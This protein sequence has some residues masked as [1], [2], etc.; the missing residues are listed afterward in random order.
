M[1][2]ENIISA[3]EKVLAWL[4]SVIF[5]IVINVQLMNQP[6]AA[7]KIIISGGL[8]KADAVC[9]KI[10]DLTKAQ[11][12]RSENADATVQGAAYM[13]AGLPQQ[14]ALNTEVEVFVPRQNPA[15]DNR[16]TRWQAAM[17][18]WLSLEVLPEK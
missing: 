8:S 17:V 14:W 11:V 15:L 6:G 10:A 12:H 9:Q 7:K 3:D 5:Q 4:E 18:D 13:A 2:S 16:F 1:T